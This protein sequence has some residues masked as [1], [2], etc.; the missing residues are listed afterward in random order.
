MSF[1]TCL[2]WGNRLRGLA[3]AALGQEEE[4]LVCL[5]RAVR[6]GRAQG[7][8]SLELRALASLAR[9]ASG[10]DERSNALRLHASLEARLVENPSIST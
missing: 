3:L 8:L 2:P 7:A 10:S 6:V 5:R 1:G 9:H 4:A